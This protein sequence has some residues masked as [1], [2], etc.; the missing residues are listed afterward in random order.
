MFTSLLFILYVFAPLGTHPMDLLVAAKINWSWIPIV[1]TAKIRKGWKEKDEK[2][3]SGSSMIL[4]EQQMSSFTIENR[5][6]YITDSGAG[7]FLCNRALRDGVKDLLLI[8]SQAWAGRTYHG[9]WANW[10]SINEWK[11]AFPVFETGPLKSANF[12]F[13]L[14]E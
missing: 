4:V 7:K 5:F 6:S 10:A 14:R 13:T 1:F 8:D 12:V 3:D 11:V 9:M 2:E